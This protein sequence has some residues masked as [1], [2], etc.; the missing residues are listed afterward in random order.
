MKY[1]SL[2]WIVAVALAPVAVAPATVSG[3]WTVTVEGNPHGHAA[4][5]LRLTQDGKQVTG[6]FISGHMPDMDVAGEFADGE[7]RLT[8]THG[9]EDEKVVF[10]GK[11][12]DDGTLAGV[13]SSPMGDMKWTARRATPDK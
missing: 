5:E 7:L 1:I 9:T 2:A 8:A 4:M 13:V 3:T 6:T 10:S 12:Q 11:L